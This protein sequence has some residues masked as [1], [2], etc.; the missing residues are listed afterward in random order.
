M[1]LPV[2]FISLLT[3]TICQ[4]QKKP[5][6]LFIFADDMAYDVMGAAG[7]SEV[8]TPHL[9]KLANRGTL[10]T[11]AYNSGAWHGAVCVASRTM[12][13]TGLQIW[14]ARKAEKGLKK[15]YVDKKLF[16]PQLMEAAGYE[17][18]FAGKWHVGNKKLA[19]EAF[20]H[21][22]NIRP[23]MPRP[24]N[25]TGYNRPKS[26]DDHDWKPWD[27]KQAGFWIG[28]KHWSEVVADD[29]ELFLAKAAK[30]DKPFFMMLAFNAPHDPRQA[31]KKFCDMYPYDKISVPKSFLPEYPHEICNNR[32]LRDEVLAPFPRTHYAVQV[33]RSEYYAIITHM[34]EQIGRILTALEKTGKA[35]DTVVIFSADHGLSVGHHGLMGKQNMYDHSVRVPWIIA[36]PGV[37]EKKQ[38]AAPIYLQDVMATA[39]ELGVAKKPEHVEF[40]SVLPHLR[41][42]GKA[43]D[44]VYS[45]YM[46][47]QRMVATDKYK[48]IKYPK[49]GVEKLFDLKNDPEEMKDLAKDAAHAEALQKM[50]KL[51]A[52]QMKKMNDPLAAK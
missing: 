38:L 26:E 33:H 43:N 25:R 4:A 47:H 8:K 18:Y 3:L 51:L 27:K 46:N 28:G 16:W 22:R 24:A 49:L 29:G 52:E 44:V 48:L 19:Q 10:F 7:H 20:Q 5:N 34:D 39:L 1:K 2:L 17:T 45:S 13:Q 40:E 36:G 41:G 21:S 37:P 23:G 30:S 31:P 35:K 14:N 9:D 32:K 6:I 12:L 50:R 11:H 42:Q 15:N